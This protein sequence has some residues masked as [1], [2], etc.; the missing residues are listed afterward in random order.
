MN[1]EVLQRI[2]DLG[3]RD[4][5]AAGGDDDRL[6]AVD[7]R[8][9]AIV[10]DLDDIAGAQPSARLDRGGRGLFVEEIAFED[11][12]I[13]QQDLAVAVELPFGA[14]QRQAAAAEPVMAAGLDEGDA[15]AFG[16]SVALRNRA[17]DD[18]EEAQRLRRDRGAGAEPVTAA[19]EAEMALDVAEQ[20]PIKQRVAEAVERRR[21]AGLPPVRQLAAPGETGL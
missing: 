11:A 3:W 8:D 14:G 21:G 9:L 5:L 15:A 1:S 4:V 18:V 6:L 13:A 2:L 12:G 16:Q 10:H 17:A 20:Q 19:G 7:H